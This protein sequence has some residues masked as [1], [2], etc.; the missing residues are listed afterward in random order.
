VAIGQ[1]VVLYAVHL[2]GNVIPE[3]SDAATPIS[4]FDVE[5]MMIWNR[6]MRHA[7][8]YED[9]EDTNASWIA[10]QS[11]S[12]RQGAIL[13][14]NLDRGKDSERHLYALVDPT[15]QD[16][17]VTDFLLSKRWSAQKK[18]PL[19]TPLGR[20]VMGLTSHERIG[21]LLAELIVPSMTIDEMRV[22]AGRMGRPPEK[23]RKRRLDLARGVAL[24]LQSAVNLASLASY[25]NVNTGTIS[26]LAKAGRPLVQQ[27]EIKR[28][29][30]RFPFE[31]W[32]ER[33][34]PVEAR[35]IHVEDDG[36]GRKT[37]NIAPTGFVFV[38]PNVDQPSLRVLEGSASGSSDPRDDDGAID[39]SGTGDPRAA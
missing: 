3:L 39:Q 12:G 30:K 23:E 26:R 8:E 14:S 19:G 25:L 32:T 38:P 28:G 20:P 36:Y 15:I 6:P 31:A 4:D 22:I 18:A 10:T 34:V 1:K 16:Q 21:E 7:K 29:G 37:K 13:S 2:S 9:A 24:S 11:P 5:H 17:I 27:K 35:V 33:F